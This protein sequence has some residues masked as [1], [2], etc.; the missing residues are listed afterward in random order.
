MNLT[1]IL[2][3]IGIL[4]F[5]LT[6]KKKILQMGKIIGTKLHSIKSTAF[7]SQFRFWYLLNTLTVTLLIF[8]YFKYPLDFFIYKISASIPYFKLIRYVLFPLIACA[9]I[10]I[11]F[12]LYPSKNHFTI[13]N[14]TST[15][16]ISLMFM[17]VGGENIVLFF[18]LILPDK[19]ELF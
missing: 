16:L 10:F 2:F 8:I 9:S 19:L 3:F 5:V 13:Y 17:C 6:R 12:N 1:I 14:F 7:Q 4:G 18:I 15:Y 11:K